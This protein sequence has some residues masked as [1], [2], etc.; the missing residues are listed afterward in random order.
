M[1]DGITQTKKDLADLL[2]LQ[3]QKWGAENVVD[4]TQPL[5]RINAKR[6]FDNAPYQ[7]D[8]TRGRIHRTGCP[9][10]P[11]SSETAL[12]A[13]WEIQANELPHACEK[14]KPQPAIGNKMIRDL[15]KDIFYGFLS[16]IDQF[17]NVISER[18]REFRQSEQGQRVERDLEKAL[19]ALDEKQRETINVVVASLQGLTDAVRLL[20]ESINGTNSGNGHRKPADEGAGSRPA[21]RPG[22]PSG[23]SNRKKKTRIRSS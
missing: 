17:G 13:L 10:I 1:S 21:R 14:C 16:I 23:G 6:E 8:I 7:F 2:A 5:L 11:R 3:L 18:G 19:A 12:Y 20:N 9:A 4:T 22:R 15:S